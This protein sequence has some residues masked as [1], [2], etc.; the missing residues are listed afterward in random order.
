[1]D[2][3]V[4]EAVD[5]QTLGVEVVEEIVDHVEDVVMTVIDSRMLDE[6][7]THT[8]EYGYNFHGSSG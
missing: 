1:M 6:R 7:S 4:D 8:A 5:L 2:R 3:A